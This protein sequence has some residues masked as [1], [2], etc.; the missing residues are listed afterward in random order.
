MPTN[1]KAHSSTET[2]C[3]AESFSV[4]LSLQIYG[5]ITAASVLLSSFFPNRNLKQITFFSYPL[6]VHSLLLLLEMP[7]EKGL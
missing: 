3:R 6:N 1:I 5:L 4:Y 7:S 2:K